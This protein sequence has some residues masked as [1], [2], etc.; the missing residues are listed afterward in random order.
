MVPALYESDE[1]DA[2]V[3]SV[4]SEVK[5]RGMV[6]TKETCWSYLINK[7]RAN[8]H[9]VLAMSPSGNTLRQRCRAFPGLVSASVID[10]YFPWPE[11]ALEKV[12]E[13]F[14]RD[15][16]LPDELRK[17]ITTHCV[18]VHTSVVKDSKRFI[19]ELRRYNYVTPKN[20]LDFISNYRN[21]LSGRKKTLQTRAK[22]LETG[23]SKLIEAAAQVDVMSVELKAAKIVVDAK[24][25]DVT[26]LIE[27]ISSR[28]SIADA[29]QAQATIKAKELEE[30]A[31]VIAAESAKATTALDA[32]LP[33]LEG[34]AA[35]LDNL[36]AKDI[37]E[38][39]S[40][41]NPPAPVKSVCLAVLVLRPNGTESGAD[42]NAAKAMM[43]N[44]QFLQ[45]L[46]KYN[47][48]DIKGSQMKNVQKFFEDP[49]IPLSME[50]MQSVS[51]AGAGLL[52]WVIA[53]KE[54]YAVAKDVE[55]LRKKVA[56]M[57]R[58]QATGEKELADITKLLA[59]LGAELAELDVKY[60]A[61]AA[62]LKD[63]SEKANLMQ[64][65][66][67][68]ANKLIVGL[69]GERVR[70]TAD[71]ERLGGNIENSTGDCLLAASFLSY[72]GP[73]TFDYRAAL[74]NS[75]WSDDIKKRKIPL[76]LPLDLEGLL[77]TDA[78]I[79]TWN[80]DGLPSDPQS[81]WNG[82]LTTKAS[83]FPLCIDPQQQAVTWIKNREGANLRVATFLDS[84]F[85]Q[86]LKL[87][88]Q[89][90]KPFLFEAVDEMLDP[91]IDVV[92]EK[93]TFMDGAQRMINIDDKAIA[94]DDNFRMYLTSKLANPHYSP[95]V[96]G[97]TQ[98]INF[99]VT[100]S[101]LEGQLLNVVVG[102]ERP[103]LATSW[104]TLVDEMSK[105]ALMLEQ[106]EEELLKNLSTSTGNILDNEELIATLDSAKTK[107][108]E[109]TEKL[110]RARLTKEEISQ[111]R[112]VYQTSAKRG[113]IL[114]FVM[115][116][117]VNV[118]K[119][120]EISLGSF[121]VVFKKALSNAKKA[122]SLEVRIKYMVAQMTK[123]M[124]DYTCTG[125]FER[126]KLMFSLQL[127]LSIAAAEGNM[128]RSELDF[129][130]K[131][132]TSIDAPKE[133]NPYTW[134]SKEGWKNLIKLANG[135]HE[136]PSGPVFA[137][138]LA[139]LK[140]REGGAAWRAWYDLE[141]PE[142]E[143]LPGGF[144]TKLSNFQA[145]CAIRCFRPDRVYNGVKRFVM[146][147]LGEAYVQPPVLDFSR[148][149]HAASPT[150]PVIFILSPG[151]D[152]QSDIQALGITM[153]FAPPTKFR[154]LAMGQGQAPK[155]EEMLLQGAQR[156]Y[157]VLLQNT[158]LLIWWLKNLERLLTTTL[159]KPHPDFRL[160]MTTDPTESYPISLLQRS[161]KVV[162]EPPDGLK[163]N[164]RSSYAKLIAQANQ[165]AGSPSMTS[166]GAGTD[167]CPHPA[168]RPLVYVL[169]MLHAVLLERRKF[170]RIGFNVSYD[171]NES[172]FNI[173]RR[174]FA[175]YLTKAFQNGDDQIPWSS[176]R[177]LIGEVQYGGRVSDSFDR[178]VLNTY[179]EEYMG[180]FLFDVNNK[181]FFARSGHDYDLPPAGTL[182]TYAEYVETLPL[183]NGPA[184]FGL[185]PNAEINMFT[186]AV[187]TMWSALI[188]MQPRTGG[189]GG[190]LSRDDIIASVV[191]DLSPKIPPPEDYMNIKKSLTQGGTIAPSPTSVV[192][193]QE[194]ERW[195]KLVGYMAQ[196]L[197]DLSRAL[198]GEIGM[199]ESLEE[200]GNALFNGTIPAP[201][202]M[203]APQSE[204]PL[205]SW[206]A[207]FLD[208]HAQYVKWINEGDPL[209][210]W[211]SGLHIPESYLTA[212]VQVTCR[213]KG[214]ALDRSTLFT[215][216]TPF[217]DVSQVTERLEDG[218]YVRG[219]YLEG[220]GW[221]VQKRCLRPQDPKVLVV[222][223]PILQVIPIEA[224]RLQLA[225]TFRTPCVAR[226][227]KCW[228]TPL[229]LSHPCPLPALPLLTVC[230][231]RSHV[232]T[233]WVSGLY[234]KPTSSHM[235]T[236]AS[237][238]CKASASASISGVSDDTDNQENNTIVTETLIP[239]H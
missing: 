143:A 103:D 49:E 119:M 62:E 128:I 83:R 140:S 155:A 29:Q 20:Y 138:L 106:L 59:K 40:F 172:D 204:K 198:I 234:L 94:W 226:K 158:H 70:W 28:Q 12:A 7:F 166:F 39:K 235:T 34:A 208:R 11:D 211:L 102:H 160:W 88:I 152:P 175:L 145:L 65:R 169:C 72:L 77:T 27:D 71:V 171:F 86:P 98:I 168:Y 238:R 63:L 66:L 221:D 209:V 173:S 42:W 167:D 192:L 217:T 154:F 137:E 85:M 161:L 96:M 78:T 61:A 229:Q 80:A 133:P 159:A 203:L 182:D 207:H 95:E 89:Y 108:I 2:L 97:K 181:F 53:I 232:V 174:C 236:R 127:T 225:G 131:G 1:K 64:K 91:M 134:L 121:L 107:S 67:A 135:L 214:W 75:T 162:T 194:L 82:I 153:G 101:G 200:L 58:A 76:T 3:N 202:K 165:E 117:L 52:Q 30:G 14:L 79:Q 184:V 239:S 185:H 157:W 176:L 193:M 45:N 231:L 69:Q 60:K 156:G 37:G 33:A 191:R 54:Y 216:T 230:T 220:A 222:D 120:Y 170:G 16:Q 132:D 233:R 74:V 148:I 237:G 196:S 25:I 186:E 35:A 228:G 223:L 38:I 147:E 32:A 177:Y 227:S 92:L 17:D 10:W 13:F 113:S 206:I 115:A 18:H 183:T 87:A 144:S 15:E 48:D 146:G 55:P 205:G 124:Y 50:S 99:C 19:D 81:I 84:D 73:F 6:D 139:H 189:G 195:N 46:K 43:S 142:M 197:I 213:R 9:L 110:S 201:W 51:K 187:M 44:G 219:L 22:R 36:S 122:P 149:F 136:S 118:N 41:A 68:A 47:K 116:G 23:L 21:Q 141:T 218:C 190:G 212:L 109:I 125:I 151:A 224:S 104:T 8:L 4:R 111:A 90:G 178:R 5:A 57:E 210:I 130:L 56:D 150:T 112:A 163:L 24:T 215:V 188:D 164:M 114:Y 179:L 129:F 100:E 31:V 26:A 199:S 105:N 126:H 180:D 93:L 123:D